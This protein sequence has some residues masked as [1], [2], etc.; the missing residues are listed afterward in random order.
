MN[1]IL[2]YFM[3]MLVSLAVLGSAGFAVTTSSKEPNSKLIA[4]ATQ[5]W[6]NKKP[7]AALAANIGAPKQEVL[8]TASE[9]DCFKPARI[10]GNP[11]TSVID[12]LENRGMDFSFAAR[13]KLADKYLIADYQGT[14]EQNVLLLEYLNDDK[15]VVKECEN[16]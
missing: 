8:G 13:K 11:N 5:N 15:D 2:P 3:I 9:I 14:A 1:K 10:S 12:F 7:D 16:G 4:K 6:Q